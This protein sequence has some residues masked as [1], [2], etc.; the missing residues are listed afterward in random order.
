VSALIHNEEEKRLC[1]RHGIY[2]WTD[3]HTGRQLGRSI[4][5][6]LF[7]NVVMIEH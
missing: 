6:R 5:I 3:R 4:N 7:S 1:N 2:R